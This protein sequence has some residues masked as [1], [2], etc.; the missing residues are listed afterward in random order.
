MPKDGLVNFADN[1]RGSISVR[2]RRQSFDRT[3]VWHR[4]FTALYSPA[5]QACRLS[6]SALLL[7]AFVLGGGQYAPLAVA[8]P[9]MGQVA[10]TKHAAMAAVEPAMPVKCSMCAASD[11]AKPACLLGCMGMQVVLPEGTGL[12]IDV[13]QALLSLTPDERLSGSAIRPDPYPPKPNPLA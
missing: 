6:L 11:M 1:R 4:H 13:A 3:A 2:H 7:L 12:P 10:D 5:M 8:A 9:Q